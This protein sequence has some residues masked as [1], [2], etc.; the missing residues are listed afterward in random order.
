M[1]LFK[2]SP[3][4]PFDIWMEILADDEVLLSFT[5]QH[6]IKQM[7]QKCK[8]WADIQPWKRDK[9]KTGSR[10][11]RNLKLNGKIKLNYHKYICSDPSWNWIGKCDHILASHWRCDIWDRKGIKYAFWDAGS[12]VYESICKSRDMQTVRTP[13]RSDPSLQ[14]RKTYP[15]IQ[16]AQGSQVK[17]VC[18]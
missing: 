8:H 12:H 9:E 17:R 1:W 11:W 15:V 10:R 16:Q 4:I 3:K 5:P 18:Q 14:H 13:N 7:A 6:N 2:T